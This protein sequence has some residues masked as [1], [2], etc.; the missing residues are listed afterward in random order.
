MCKIL[1]LCYPFVSQPDNYFNANCSFWNYSERT[2]MGYWSTQG[3]KLVDT[4]KTHTTC[5]CSHLTNFAILMARRE[6]VVSNDISSH[7]QGTTTRL[8]FKFLARSKI[9][10]VS[11]VFI[12]PTHSFQSDLLSV[13]LFLLIHKVASKITG[14][15]KQGWASVFYKP[16][17]K[18]TDQPYNHFIDS[19]SVQM[20][21]LFRQLCKLFPGSPNASSPWR[22][23]SRNFHTGCLNTSS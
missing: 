9:V 16:Y 22:G 14:K 5:A 21:Y 17:F 13:A 12:A 20:E 18:V 19:P 10:E 15:R 6:I 4:N 23:R 3:C 11:L 2:M 1:I 7:Q 8:G